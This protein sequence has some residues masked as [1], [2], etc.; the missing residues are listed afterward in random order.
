[1][2][3]VIVEGE[4]EERDAKTA[5]EWVEAVMLAAYESAYDTFPSRICN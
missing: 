5:A 4:V 1:M 2:H 3:L